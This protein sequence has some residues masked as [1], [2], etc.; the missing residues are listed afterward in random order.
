[1]YGIIGCH[2]GDYQ[3]NRGLLSQPFPLM[4]LRINRILVAVQKNGIAL[5]MDYLIYAFNILLLLFWIRLWS[6]PDK[7]FYFNPFLSGTI[8]ITDTV[9]AF[10]RPVLFLPEQVAAVVILLFGILFKTLLF[11]RLQVTWS[12]KLGTFFQFSPQAVGDQPGPLL[13]FSLLHFAEFLFTLWTVY[14]LVRLITPP[15]RTNRATEAFAFFARPFSRLPLL[16]QPVVLFALHAM[17]ALIVSRIGTLSTITQITESPKQVMASPFLTGPFPAQV[18]KTGWLAALSFADGLSMLTR[19]LFIFILGNLGAAI[20]QAQ[21]AAMICSEGAE[22][23]LGRFARARVGGMG[24]DFTPLIFFFVVDM[25][26]N[27]ICMG[28]FKLIHLPM[29]N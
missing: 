23:L 21:G 6:A 8:K 18:L 2:V 25:M 11:L 15:F 9:L 20:L 5:V 16:A 27:S 28:L 26:Y 4:N 19:A 29:F 22:L 10:L 17:L 24:F 3:H 12:I 1:M 14:L 13:L 7:E